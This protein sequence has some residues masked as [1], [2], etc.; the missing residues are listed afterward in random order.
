MADQ[1]GPTADNVKNQQAIE[2]SQARQVDYAQSW[3]QALNEGNDAIEKAN[4][5][6]ENQTEMAAKISGLLEDMGGHFKDIRGKSAGFFKALDEL[7][8]KE[9]GL[10]G[11]VKQTKLWGIG[12]KALGKTAGGVFKTA[13]GLTSAFKDIAIGVLDA[14]VKHP[15]VA[16]I[17]AAYK[18]LEKVAKLVSAIF[19][20]AIKYG[21]QFAK[22]MAGLPLKIAGVAA[23]MGNSLRQ[24]LIVT[25]GTAIESTKE[26]FDISEKYGSGAG[27]AIKSF[28]DTA[29]ASMLEFRDITSDS[30]KLFG[31]GANGISERAKVAAQRLNEMGAYA[32]IF[33]ESLAAK[34]DGS[35]VQF[36]FMEKS[37][38]ILGMTAEDVAY[39]AQ[40]AAKSGVS[41]NTILMDTQVSLQNV[42]KSSGVNAKTISKNFNVLR[43]DI[44]NFGHLTTT[45]LQQ[46][47]AELVK[48]GLSAQDA[49]QMFGKLDTFESAAQMSAMLSQSFGMNLDALKL[50]RAENPKEI[51]EDLRTAMMSTGRSFEQLN[52]H[53]KSLL[54][55]TT[56]MSATALKSLMDFRDAGMSYEEAMKKMKENSPEERQFKAFD[57][58][59]GSLKEIKNI[60]QDTS[61]FSSFFKGLR[62]AI[63]YA[64]GIDKSFIRVS[65]RMEDFYLGALKLG[66]DKDLMEGFGK[67]FEPIKETINALIGTGGNDKG[68]FDINKVV[69]TFKPFMTK[70]TNILGD[71]FSGE[72]SVYRLQKE[73]SK[74][75]NESFDFKKIM[76]SPDNPAMTL[77][78]TG[79]KLV[80]QVLKGFAVI[81]PGLIDSMADGFEGLVNFLDSGADM[82]LSES[83]KKI[84]GL[85]DN[86]AAS[87]TDSIKKVLNTITEKV[88]PSFFKLGKPIFKFIYN[89]VE[90]IIDSVFD[91]VERKFETTAIGKFIGYF[92]TA[93]GSRTEFL[94]DK[95]LAKKL[96]LNSSDIDKDLKKELYEGGDEQQARALGKLSAILE[97]EL[98]KTNSRN[99]KARLSESLKEIDHIINANSY[100]LESYMGY[101]EK[102]D[103]VLRSVEKNQKNTITI[104][105]SKANDWFSDMFGGSGKAVVQQSS[106]GMS[107]TSLAKGDQMIAGMEGGPIVNAIR[108]SGEA[109]SHLVDYITE[110]ISVRPEGNVNIVQQGRPTDNR[111][112]Q[113][114]LNVDGKVL[115]KTVV[116]NNVIGYATDPSIAGASQTLRNVA[117]RNPS[118]GSTEGSSLA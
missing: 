28:A 81:G 13:M 43:K 38:R 47:S 5:K 16:F 62:T 41:I 73:F 65:K 45:Q 44:I 116:A 60:M 54:A 27:S 70:F 87:I 96:N 36:E 56:G 8:D 7:S 76:Q 49:A 42:A 84:F 88:I 77:I 19:F 72:K 51:F 105:Q 32:D 71:T 102:L 1:T 64:S 82:P 78:K 52:R 80:G 9:K 50:I 29:S 66:K 112:I 98:S 6:Y 39:T 11:I 4:K 26:L 58:M 23:K 114:S 46:T 34:A 100:R 3:L 117:I 69:K 33:G 10:Q 12:I 75:M 95:N 35:A 83:F 59:S 115:A 79:G 109:V 99:E 57:K 94:E 89:A 25:I 31:T 17:V 37:L 68:L 90:M 21:I 111:P 18:A 86:D 15:V 104:K 74:M 92:T 24:D 93:P 97:K 40:E 108:Y 113:V 53:E 63:G 118:G 107:V 55:S 67:A 110:M 2:E 85:T 22:F 101:K 91:I 103:N 48:M 30:V 20:G 106:S 61:F 14:I